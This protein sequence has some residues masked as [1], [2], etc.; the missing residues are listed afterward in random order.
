MFDSSQMAHME[1][2]VSDEHRRRFTKAFN[3]IDK[4]GRGRIKIGELKSG[5]FSDSEDADYVLEVSST[6][7][8]CD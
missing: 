2:Y 4:T 1:S 7:F 6:A 5:M 3:S 8:L